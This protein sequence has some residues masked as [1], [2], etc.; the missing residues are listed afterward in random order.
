MKWKAASCPFL[1]E[2]II[3]SPTIELLAASVRQAPAGH[4]IVTIDDEY[5]E[6]WTTAYDDEG[7]LYCTDSTQRKASQPRLPWVKGEDYE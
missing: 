6:T 7:T 3:R 5:R 2:S 4:W 1:E